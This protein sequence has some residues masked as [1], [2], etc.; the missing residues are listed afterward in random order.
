VANKNVVFIMGSGHSGSTL[1]ELVLGSH[2]RVF[3]LGEVVNLYRGVDGPR[4]PF[5]RL[6]RICEERCPFWNDTVDI[7]VLE[8][9]FSRAGYLAPI[10]RWIS[11]QRENVY[12]RFFDWSG[13]DVL[14]DSSKRAHWIA[15]QL[16]PRRNW[17]T[18]SPLLI[19]LTRDGR[20][21]V[22]SKLRKYPEKGIEL[23]AREWK[24]RVESMND[25]FARY[26]EGGRVKISYENLANN[27]ESTARTICDFLHLDF[28]P[29]MLRFWK[30]DH[31]TTFGNAGTRS[32]IARFRAQS[33]ERQ[34]ATPASSVLANLRSRHGTHY[35]DV[36]LAIRLD[37]RWKRELTVEQLAAFEAIAGET[38]RPFVYDEAGP[39]TAR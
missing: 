23:E 39:S 7:R 25:F 31:H 14:I 8:A 34:A 24:A 9:H 15:Q 32:L 20:A 10:R 28:E 27:P 18:F 2:P 38:N 5:P 11:H 35:D 33:A 36:G 1:L 4:D 16:Q 3:G 30:H 37:L 21:V 6:C 13:K 22:N 17:K 19:Y 26:P 12:Q 29:E